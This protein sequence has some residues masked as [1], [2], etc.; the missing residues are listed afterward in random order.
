[1]DKIKKLLNKETVL[2][3]IFGVATT[4]VSFA[5]YYLLIWPGMHYLAAQV[6]SWAAAVVF[7]F[8]VNKIFVFED[9]DNSR[10]GLLRQI[11]QFVSVRLL[12]LG[13]ETFL[14]WLMVDIAHI[15]EGIAKIPVSVLTVIIN[16]VASKLLI[17]RKK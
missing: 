1:M 6:L 17:F 14:L 8:A 7:A 11:W 15:G 9:K 5:V 16:Y 10:A 12:S 4:V 13:L 2:Y 3:I